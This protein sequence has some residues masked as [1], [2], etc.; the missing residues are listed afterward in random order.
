M[1]ACPLCGRPMVPGPSVNEHH[2]VPRR[3]GGRATVTMHRVCHD[4]IHAVLDEAELRDHYHTM[5]RLRC[6]P[7]IA[8]FL[9]WVAR[10]P[11]EFVDGH[12]GGRGKRRR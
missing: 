4:K 10:K 6:H 2:T 9:R 8:T 7:E 5:E 1:N 11:P 3:Y 12:H